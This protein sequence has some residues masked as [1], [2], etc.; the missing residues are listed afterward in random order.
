MML[1]CPNERLIHEVGGGFSLSYLTQRYTLLSP[2]SGISLSGLSPSSFSFGGG[3]LVSLPA[4]LSLGFS[5]EDWPQWGGRPLRNMYSPAKGLPDIFQ[6]P[7]CL[8]TTSGE[9]AP[10][11]CSFDRGNAQQ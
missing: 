10:F 9:T 5:A 4:G 6:S 8:Q 7:P 2:L 3:M 11:K 1:V